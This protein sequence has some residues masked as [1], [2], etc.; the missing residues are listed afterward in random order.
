LLAEHSGGG[1]IAGSCWSASSRYARKH[2][3]V[4]FLRK[5]QIAQFALE[6]PITVREG[7]L[8]QPTRAGA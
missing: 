5:D 3:G 8:A 2:P 4:V 6:S 1:L 7:S